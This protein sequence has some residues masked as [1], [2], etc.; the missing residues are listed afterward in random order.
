ME[1]CFP[2]KECWIVMCITTSFS[3][4]PLML[5]EESVH[6][7]K[8]W[9]GRRWKNRGGVMTTPG[10]HDINIWG[11]LSGSVC[12]RSV[13]IFAEYDMNRES[14]KPLQ[15]ISTYPTWKSPPVI[16]GNWSGVLMMRYK[17]P[18]VVDGHVVYI[19]KT[20]LPFMWRWMT[21]N[22]LVV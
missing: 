20:R 15:S 5:N 6:F 16:V 21:R 9:L 2:G 14:W 22:K 1:I 12:W 7:C 11:H 3:L 13:C 18:V 17:S 19:Q 8:S 4:W 10:M